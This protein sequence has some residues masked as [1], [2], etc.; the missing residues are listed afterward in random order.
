MTRESFR[1]SSTNHARSE[2]TARC[3]ETHPAPRMLVQPSLHSL[4]PMFL[5]A[6]VPGLGGDERLGTN[7]TYIG[8]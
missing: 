7:G 2:G 8:W 6:T 3:P 5:D 1:T 4:A